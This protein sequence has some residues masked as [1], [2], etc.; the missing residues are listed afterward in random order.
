MTHAASIIGHILV[1]DWIDARQSACTEDHPNTSQA[2]PPRRFRRAEWQG[3]A[4]NRPL[5]WPS[6]AASMRQVSAGLSRR[7]AF[8]RQR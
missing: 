1:R 6:Y 2:Q 7:V 8:R 4:G 3:W 5:S